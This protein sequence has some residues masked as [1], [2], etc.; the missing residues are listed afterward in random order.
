MIVLGVIVFI[1]LFIALLRFGVTVEYG[2]GGFIVKARVGILSLRIFPRKISP[3]RAE[4]K[5]GKKA[6]RKAERK[7]KK[8]KKKREK[9]SGEKS[10]GGLEVFNAALPAAKTLLGRLRRRILI[11]RLVF[12]YTSAGSDPVKTAMSFGAANAA[13]CAITPLIENNFRVR[14][15]D[16]RVTA[17]FD[18]AEP[19]IY[20]NAAISLAVWEAFYIF[21]AML[22]VLRIRSQG[23]GKRGA[24]GNGA[25]DD[26]PRPTHTK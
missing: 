15:R 13:F 3:K 19:G 22:P 24:A 12:W 14:R 18:A 2:D 4:K 17:D 7:E 1:L 8:A 10:P 23:S 25:L 16:L 11:K 9:K 6:K 21:F 26:V 20:L 5:A